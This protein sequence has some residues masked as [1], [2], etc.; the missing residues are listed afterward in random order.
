M[1]LDLAGNEAD[2]GIK[3]FIPL[4]SR[5]RNAGLKLTIHAGEWG[6]AQNVREAVLELEADRIGHGIRVLEDPLR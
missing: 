6:G 1:G 2:Y 3:G 5:A 4:L